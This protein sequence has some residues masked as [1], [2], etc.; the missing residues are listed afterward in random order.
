MRKLRKEKWVF[1]ENVLLLFIKYED[2]VGFDEFNGVLFIG[3]VFNLLII[4]VGVGIMVLLVIMKFLGF[5]FGIVMIMFIV[6]LIERFI[7]MLFKFSRVG[8][9]VFYVGVMVDV[10][11]SVGR[12][13]L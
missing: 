5:G 6:F 12:I 13:L 11:G 9:F 8:K 10:F 3:V 4:I 2:E 1:D 7:D